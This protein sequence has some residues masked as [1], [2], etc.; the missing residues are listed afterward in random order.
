MFIFVF[1]FIT[2]GRVYEKILLRFMWKSVHEPQMFAESLFTIAKAWKQLTSSLK[3][4][5]MMWYL[6]SIEYYSAIKK[7]WNNA[8]CRNMCGLRNYHTKWSKSDRGRQISHKV[9]NM[10][11]LIKMTKLTIQKQTQDFKNQRENGGRVKWRGGID[12][13]TL[14]YVK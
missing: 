4:L 2:L 11:N 5:T 9:I 14:L 13:Y 7:A 3:E 8:I 12:I 10:W 6:Q 1:I